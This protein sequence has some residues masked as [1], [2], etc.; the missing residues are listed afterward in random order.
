MHQDVWVWALCRGAGT[1]L[2][3][4]SLATARLT[5]T[6]S[7]SSSSSSVALKS[8]LRQSLPAFLTRKRKLIGYRIVIFSHCQCENRPKQ[9]PKSWSQYGNRQSPVHLW[10]DSVP[11]SVRLVLYMLIF[12]TELHSIPGHTGLMRR[13]HIRK[14]NLPSS[15]HIIFLRKPLFTFKLSSLLRVIHA[16]NVEV[17]HPEWGR[18]RAVAVSP[19]HTYFCAYYSGRDSGVME[20]LMPCAPF[21]LAGS[22]GN[23]TLHQWCSTWT[24]TVNKRVI[25]SRTSWKM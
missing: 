13:S 16:N 10:C 21:F 3:L 9:T 8:S 4:I 11:N 7:V 20:T 22:H 15:Q 1:A 18:T 25:A 12:M 5:V 6:S 14:I 17:Q 2:Q 19:L 24:H 23:M